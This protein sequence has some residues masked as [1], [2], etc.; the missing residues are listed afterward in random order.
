[1]ET[2]A[3]TRNWSSCDGLNA[4]DESTAAAASSNNIIDSCTSTSKSKREDCS[5][6][7]S[8]K[9]FKTDTTSDSYAKDDKVYASYWPQDADRGTTNPSWHPGTIKG[10]YTFKGGQRLYNVVF[11]DGDTIHDLENGDIMTKN[12][13]IKKVKKEI[14]PLFD[15]GDEVYAAYWPGD[16]RIASTPTW[17]PGKIKNYHVE[18]GS[19]GGEYG[20]TRFYDVE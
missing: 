11:D 19:G 16:N 4:V 8:I 14:K 20:P 10:Y 7:N 12:Q 13:Y 5:M 2:K 15:K 9:K 18:K 3:A 6:N 1:M 17:Y